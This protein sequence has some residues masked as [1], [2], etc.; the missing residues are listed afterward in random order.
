MEMARQEVKVGIFGGCFDP[1][2]IGHLIIAEFACLQFNLEKVIFVP[3][4]I[5]PHKKKVSAT[6]QQ[7]LEMLKL[8]IGGNKNF[9]I[10]DIEVKREGPSYTY[11]TVISF[12]STNPGAQFYFLI[13]EDAFEEL[14]TW[15]KIEKL[16]EEIIFLVAPRFER[17]IK[18]PD[19]NFKVKY[20]KIDSPRIEIS[21]SFLRNLISS[22][23]YPKYLIPEKVLD[24]IKKEK[25]YGD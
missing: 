4:K 9:E 8:A 10:S 1:V 19:W 17:E 23:I 18:I 15:Y 6:P 21:S 16:V 2:H 5:P 7:R 13:G 20:E 24:Y 25:I 3:A 22:G 12:K 11:D 14:H